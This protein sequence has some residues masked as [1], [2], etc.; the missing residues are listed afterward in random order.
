MELRALAL[1]ALR[2][3]DPDAKVAA[4]RA[5]QAGAAAGGVAV[6]PC[7]VLSTVTTIRHLTS[8]G[9]RQDVARP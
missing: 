7:V 8:H 4:V 3:A 9:A 6:D 5:L 2:L 1:E